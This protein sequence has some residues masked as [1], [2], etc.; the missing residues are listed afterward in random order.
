VN[1]DLYVEGGGDRNEAL[2]TRYRKAF[3][4]FFRRAGIQRG[5][6]SIIPCG[7]RR[8]AYDAFRTAVTIAGEHR[9]IILI[10][11]EA[12]VTNPAYPWRHVANR[13]RWARPR[14]VTN[15]QIHFMAQAMEAWFHADKESLKKYYGQHFKKAALSPRTNVEEIPKADLFNGLKRATKNCQKGEYSKGQHSFDILGRIDPSRVAA[16]SPHADRLL[17]ALAAAT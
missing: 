1:V 14:G 11:S 3:A 6:L 10:D 8:H 12:P 17:K 9:P 13:D 7:G 5:T 16:G 15:H 2:V 4:E